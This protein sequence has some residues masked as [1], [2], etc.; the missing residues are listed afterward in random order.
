M[1]WG[2]S[3]PE[4]LL[5]AWDDGWPEGVVGCNVGTPVG[6]DGFWDGCAL[7]CSDSY[8]NDIIVIIKNCGCIFIHLY[9]K[10]RDMTLVGK[11]LYIND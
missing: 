3:W 1:I 7:G 5:E 6:V 10:N 2:E 11:V 8:E 9:N 4:G